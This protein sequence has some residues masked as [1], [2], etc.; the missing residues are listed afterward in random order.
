MV[1]DLKSCKNVQLR[2]NMTTNVSPIF[3]RNSKIIFYIT[4][5]L[6]LFCVSNATFGA[7]SG[8]P[9]SEQA[10]GTFQRTINRI[11][12]SEKEGTRELLKRADA[13]ILKDPSNDRYLAGRAQLYVDLGEYAEAL[14]DLDHA[15]K[16]KS[17]IQIYHTVRASVLGH[18]RRYTEELAEID[19]ALSVGPPTADLFEMRSAM[20]SIM[21]RF[22]EALHDADEAIKLDPNFAKAFAMRAQIYAHQSNWKLAK[23]E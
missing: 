12:A 15:I 7:D 4:N 6:A 2:L 11:D 23:Q 8:I 22:P 10:A 1:L 5:L 21:K 9:N 13:M 17:S 14:S 16:L 18:L 3:V 19:V 20:L